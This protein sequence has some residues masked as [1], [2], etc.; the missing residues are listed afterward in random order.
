LIHD[1]DDERTQGDNQYNAENDDFMR[2]LLHAVLDVINFFC[3]FSFS[4]RY[5]LWYDKFRKL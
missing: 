3:F 1:V 5:N 2:S 4:W